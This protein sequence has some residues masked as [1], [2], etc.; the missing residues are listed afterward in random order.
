MPA[1]GLGLWKIPK[2]TCADAVY[3]AIKIGYRLLDGACDYANEK[4]AGEGVHRAIK[5]GLVKRE[6]LFITTKLWNTYHRK[7]QQGLDESLK[8]LGLSYVD[9]YLMHWPVAMNANGNDP[10]FPR[11]PDGSRDIDHERTQNWTD[12]W[13]DMEKL[14]DSRKVKAIGT[15]NCSAPWME[16]LLKVAMVVPAV[17][18]I[19]RHPYLPQNDV[20]EVCKKNGIVVTA[21]S[22]LGSSDSPLLEDEAV[23]SVASK[24]STSPSSVLLG[25]G[26]AYGLVIIPKSITPARIESN[27]NI[28]EL[29]KEDVAALDNISKTKGLKRFVYP[30]FNVPLGFPDKP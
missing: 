3:D 16:K 26:A 1:I 25:W 14:L 6:D 23:K 11:L 20:I 28:A 13:A 30:P 19:E 5:D 21:Y 24:H 22:P 17:N 4:E 18:Q 8:S 15:S 10:L 27:M 9:L 29:D 7:V 2:N 12:T